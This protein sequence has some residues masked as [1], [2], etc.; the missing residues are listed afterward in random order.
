MLL[1][2]MCQNSRLHGTTIHYA[3][4]FSK[5]KKKV[6]QNDR[7]QSWKS[8]HVDEIGNANSKIF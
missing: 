1:N 8:I 5:K 7:I 6:N 4:M 3:P 2:E